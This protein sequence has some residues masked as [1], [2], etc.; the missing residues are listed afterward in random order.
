M[1]TT[2]KNMTFDVNLLPLTTGDHNL[3]SSSL[4][5][6]LHVNTINGTEPILTD[7]KNTA[8]STNSASKLYLIGATS[9]A[10]NPTTN[11][12]KYTYTKGGLLSV[13]E[14]GLNLNGTE[15]AHMEWND[16]DQSIDFVFN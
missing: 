12:Y 8:G 7:T 10:A 16:T 1:A 4:K 6:N 5:W 14:L 11:S 13:S 3:G 9:Q 2:T 15:K